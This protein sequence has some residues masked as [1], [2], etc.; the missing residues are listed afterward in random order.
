M[1]PPP[2]V[3]VD[4]VMVIVIVVVVDAEVPPLFVAVDMVG[5]L[6]IVDVGLVITGIELGMPIDSFIALAIDVTTGV[7]LIIDPMLGITEV[8][9][10]ICRPFSLSTESD[11][12][13]YVLRAVVGRRSCS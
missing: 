8:I 12:C 2:L 4:P 5:A 9:D 7:G 10:I 1:S 3:G 6:D 13:R 11:A